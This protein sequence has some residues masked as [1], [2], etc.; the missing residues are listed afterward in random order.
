MHLRIGENPSAHRRVVRIRC[1]TMMAR[2]A[3]EITRGWNLEIAHI[4]GSNP[5]GAM[6]NI[7]IREI[8][9]GSNPCADAGIH[10]RQPII[11]FDQRRG[12]PA[13]PARPPPSPAQRQAPHHITNPGGMVDVICHGASFFT[14]P[15]RQKI[16]GDEVPRQGLIKRARSANEG[17]VY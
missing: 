16:E 5:H 14:K 7:G 13:E 9:A 10:Q 12:R 17:G 2:F 4:S 3:G 8:P 1:V 15:Q 6:R 11:G